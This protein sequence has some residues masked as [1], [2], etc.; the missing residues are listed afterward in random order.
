MNK[1]YHLLIFHLIAIIF[2]GFSQN[3]TIWQI[4]E[5]DNS[6][7]GMAMSP[8]KY[9]QFVANDFG[10]EDGFFLIGFHNT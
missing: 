8:N 10:Y 7:I 2:L 3:K 9:K 4:G 1:R 5:S 6:A